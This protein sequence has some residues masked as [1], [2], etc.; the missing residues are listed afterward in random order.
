M[1]KNEVTNENISGAMRNAVIGIVSSGAVIIYLTFLIRY[2]FYEPVLQSLALT[3]EQLGILYGLY[4]T[5]AMISY[6]PGGILADKIRVKYL[7]TAGFA[8]SALL[9]FWYSTLPSYNQLL[10]IFPL[11]GICTTFIF[12]GIRYK[13]IRLVSDDNTYSRNIGISYGIVGILGLAINFISMWIFGLFED[14]ATGFNMVLM[15]Y[16]GLNILCAVAS[17]IFIPKFK[18]EIIKSQKKFDLSELVA[19]IKH[20]GVWLTTM[21]MFFTY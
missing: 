16:A 4:G 1:N 10:I 9:T 5:T 7:A 20:P 13:G 19:A 6:L 14:S 2:V 18:D 11:M 15:F 3:N 17:F 8:I 12:W 21:C